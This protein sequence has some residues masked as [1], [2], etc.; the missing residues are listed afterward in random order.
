MGF[1]PL[2]EHDIAESNMVKKYL[3]EKIYAPAHNFFGI[4]A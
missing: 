1:L 2:R 4:I 3:T